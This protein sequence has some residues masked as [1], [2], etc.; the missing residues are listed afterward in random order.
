MHLFRKLHL[1]YVIIA[2]ILFGERLMRLSG[3]SD[4][5]LVILHIDVS[6]TSVIVHQSSDFINA[7]PGGHISSITAS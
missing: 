7:A 1:C 4:H 2:Q 6:E 5:L 3:D